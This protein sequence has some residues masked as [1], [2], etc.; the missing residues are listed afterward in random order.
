MPQHIILG[1]EGEQIAC[2]YLITQGF[3]IRETN[4]RMGKLE[5]DI[6][7]HKP[8]EP[9]LHIVEVKSRTSDE[10][11]DPMQ[12]ITAGKIRNLVNAANSYINY[13]QLPMA[14]QYD[15][16]I[17]VG[18]ALDDYKIHFIPDAF[19]PPLRTIR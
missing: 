8:D 10:H 16:M 5:I 12:A 17:I 2:E 14:V 1:K 9:V 7:A 15:V 3:T 4:W 18:K 19:E 11:F 6:V 13:Y